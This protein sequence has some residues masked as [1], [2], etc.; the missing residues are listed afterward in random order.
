M[1][2]PEWLGA[3]WRE[4]GAVVVSTV[5]IYATVIAYTRLAGLRSFSK[6]SSYDFAITVAFGSVIASTAASPS[7]SVAHG[8]VALGMLY[9]V[10]AAVGLARR[11]SGAQRIVDNQPRLLMAGSRVLHDNLRA[12]RISEG[13]LRARL[14]EANVLDPRHI[15][16]VVME[17]TGDVVVLHGDPHGPDLDPG[18][19]QDVIGA[20]ELRR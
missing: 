3:P 19:M 16:A 6:M 4:L 15:R 9:A 14:R 13:D 17:T 10:Q 18:L 5:L 8:A 1:S 11:R 7:V 12:G 2:V 20:E